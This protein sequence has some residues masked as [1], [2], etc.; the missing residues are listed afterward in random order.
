MVVRSVPQRD[1]SANELFATE[2]GFNG[3]QKVTLDTRFMYVPGAQAKGFPYHIWIGQGTDKQDSRGG[4]R[5]PNTSGYFHSVQ[6]RKA[7]VQ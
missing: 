5:F 3:R 6:V 7:D 1:F 4:S 2:G